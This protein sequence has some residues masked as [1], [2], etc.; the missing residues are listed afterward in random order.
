MLTG[1]IIIV[2][3]ILGVAVAIAVLALVGSARGKQTPPRRRQPF[4]R[5][6]E[7]A[8]AQALTVQ[9]QPIY[10]LGVVDELTKRRI[11]TAR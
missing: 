11:R 10:M 4:D 1:A 6:T 8:I 5:D 7:R 9:D 3:A 2:A